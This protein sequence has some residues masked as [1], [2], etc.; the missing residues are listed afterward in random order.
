MKIKAIALAIIAIL[1]IS[2]ILIAVDAGRRNNGPKPGTDFNG[3]HYNLNLI[4]KKKEMP[5]DY[6]NPDRHTMFVPLN[7]SDMQ[8]P[9][10]TPNEVDPAGN[11][12][13]PQKNVTYM[14]GIRINISQSDD[15]EF[16]M[17]Y[18]DA[19]D[20]FGELKIADGKY[21]VYI[22]VKAKSPKFKDAYTDITGWVEA[23]DNQGTLWYY[24]PVGTVSVR[25]NGKWTDGTD[26]FFVT[27][28]EDPFGYYEW[29][30][31]YTPVADYGLWVFDYMSG[32]DSWYEDSLE[33]AAYNFSS[34]GY[35]WQ[36]DNRGNKLIQVRFYP[37]D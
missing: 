23:Y 27:Q 25:K 32:L 30:T 33:T 3:P 12:N 11:L 14:E 28:Q 37:M 17:I 8:F 4:G 9:L 10:N 18:G 29:Q 5:G 13:G 36:L 21:Y 6:N 1:V 2:G 26:L 22:A 19:T 35:F 20:G 15:D 7:S 16:Y 31:T 34:L 24:I